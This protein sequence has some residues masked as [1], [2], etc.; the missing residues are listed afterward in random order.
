MEIFYIIKS[1]YVFLIIIILLLFKVRKLTRRP[2]DLFF[3][4]KTYIESHR[5]M[6]KEIFQNTIKSY[7]RAIDY[8]LDSL[9]IDVWLTKDNVPVLHHGYGEF[10]ELY[11]YY[12]KPGNITNLTWDELSTYRT[13]KD[14]LKMPK[15]SEAMKLAKNK[16]LINLEIKDRRVDLVFPH[17]VKLIEEYDFFN[18]I[19][20][21]SFH[22]EYYPKIEEYN[23]KNNKNI[24]FGFIYPK[25]SRYRFDYTKP[26][27]ILSIYWA[28]ATKTILDTAH[29]NNMAVL[30]WFD[31][32]DKETKE[33]YKQLIEN[34]ID[35]ICSNDPLLA[36]KYL[37][38]YK[39]KNI[40]NEE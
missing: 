17:I 24:I 30:A 11:G 35:T 28:D 7:S 36:R 40:I 32:I 9:E 31:M 34:G 37:R 13:I 19:I 33:I 10:G 16:I 29:K 21:S 8:K 15:L 25:Y 6:N 20:L 12:D 26:G 5:G 2:E 23:K 22:H 39:M 3:F 27:N 1:I 18:Q 14:R 38:Y 4:N